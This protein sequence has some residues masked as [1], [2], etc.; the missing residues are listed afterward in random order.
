MLP[1]PARQRTRFLG[2][3]QRAAGVVDGGQYL[4]AVAHDAGIAHQAV[5]V[6]VGVAGHPFE[7]EIIEGFAEGLAL[8]QDGDPRHACLKALQADLFVEP[9]VVRD[10]PPPFMVVV[11]GH[12]RLPK[13]ARHALPIQDQAR[14]GLGHGVPRLRIGL[15][16]LPGTGQL[17]LPSSHLR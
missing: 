1:E 3:R 6:A 17:V 10:G 7:I 4:A 12:D 16:C 14:V 2:Q 8:A 9:A 13:A 5:H 15:H 11:V